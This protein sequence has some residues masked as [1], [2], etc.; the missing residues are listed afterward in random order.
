MALHIGETAPEFSLP[1]KEGKVH[2]L[3]DY[4]GKW[5]VLYF[6]PKDN[7]PGCTIEAC[8]MRDHFP[9]FEKVKAAMLGVSA[10]PSASHRKFS[11]QYR[12]PFTLLSDE[13]KE[14]LARYGVWA[15]KSM[16][17]RKYMG[18][19]RTTFL[20]D[21]HGKIAKIYEKVK[22]AGHA[23]EILADMRSLQAA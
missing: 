9:A 8:G 2:S 15:E 5:V 1:D 21:P 10:D 18:I 17:G 7:T 13:S 12:L 14:T 16:M 11:D 23:E 19:L 20:I 22:P 4:R 6:Y 3:K